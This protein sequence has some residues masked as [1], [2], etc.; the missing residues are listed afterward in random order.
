MPRVINRRSFVRLCLCFAFLAFLTVVPKAANPLFV[1]VEWQT[2]ANVTIASGVVTKTSG[3]DGCPDGS[4]LSTLLPTTGDVY[5]RFVPNATGTMVVGLIQDGTTLSASAF[6]LGFQISADGYWEVREAGVWVA[7]GMA[8]PTD[9]FRIGLEGDQVRYYVSGHVVY[10]RNRAAGTTYRFAGIFSDM[11]A[12][13]AD[14][15]VATTSVTSQ[16]AYAPVLWSSAANLTVGGST[17]TK[18]SGCDGCPDAFAVSGSQTGS[19]DAYLEFPAVLDK[20]IVVGFIPTG[21]AV[22]LGAIDYG[23]GFFAD[24]GWDVREGDGYRVDGTT[25]QGDIFRIALEGTRVTY[26]RNGWPIWTSARRD[27]ISYRAVV[28]D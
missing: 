17:V 25:G 24:G 9:E 22:S 20:R 26:Y 28:L 15:A 14:A 19:Q 10:S 6:A 2:T 7:E 23:V 13:L 18:T 27:G 4:V 5:V 8:G 11:G 16:P 21:E 1:P 12:G 3:C